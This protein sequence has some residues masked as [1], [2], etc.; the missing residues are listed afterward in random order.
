MT[1]ATNKKVLVKVENV[2]PAHSAEDQLD[3]LN[4]I[5][6]LKSNSERNKKVS[7]RTP[8]IVDGVAGVE[9][10]TTNANVRSDDSK[11]LVDC[12]GF[13]P[14]G[15]S[16]TNEINQYLDWC[17]YEQFFNRLKVLLEVDDPTINLEDALIARAKEEAEKADKEET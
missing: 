15:L 8:K 7:T 17:E 14:C 16:D 4:L 2:V 5:L 9:I 11:E 13:Y 1:E 6:T 12:T 10:Y 3:I